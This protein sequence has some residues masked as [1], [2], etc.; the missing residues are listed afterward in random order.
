MA[1]END[2][3]VNTTHPY[4]IIKKQTYMCGPP[5]DNSLLKKNKIIIVYYK[6]CE[7]ASYFFRGSHKILYTHKNKQFK[8]D[9]NKENLEE[10]KKLNTNTQ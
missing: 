4:K 2:Q 6:L 8:K 1:C 9:K 7:I 5:T 3:F 10:K